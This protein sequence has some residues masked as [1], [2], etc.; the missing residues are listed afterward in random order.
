MRDLRGMLF[1]PVASNTR[2][3][4]PYH[5]EVRSSSMIRRLLILGLATLVGL[6]PPDLL[7]R[8]VGAW[9]TSFQ[10]VDPPE[11]GRSRSVLSSALRRRMSNFPRT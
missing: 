9:P 7:L 6:V 5:E 1:S 2:F 3:V 4:S 10:I 8:V 11:S